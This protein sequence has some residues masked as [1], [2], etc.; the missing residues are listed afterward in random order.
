LK[1]I[2]LHILDVV[3]NGISAGA[4]LIRV[5]IWEKR[6]K[7]RLEIT[8]GDNGRGIPENIRKTVT[9]PFVTT[10]TTRRVGLG[11]SLLKA[12]ALRCNGTFEIDSETNRGT[13]I[14]ASFEFDHIDRAP[15][16]DMPATVSSLLA[17][18]PEID[19]DYLH[20]ING[21]EFRLDTREL[22]CELDDMSLSDPRIVLQLESAIR[23]HLKAM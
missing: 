8:I 10:R 9:D 16:G 11:L 22:R 3:E 5:H 2:S 18:H 21:N 13:T 6:R 12:A 15:I 23:D 20:S 4:T 19:L 17:G 7:N 14:T 1:E